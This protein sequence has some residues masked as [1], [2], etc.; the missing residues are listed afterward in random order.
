MTPK[1]FALLNFTILPGLASA[2]ACNNNC[3]RQVIGTAIREPPSLASRSSLCADFMTTYVTLA[4]SSEPS[5]PLQPSAVIDG[6]NVH[7]PRQATPAPAVTGTK[8]SYASACTDAAAYWSACQCF[9]GIKPTTITLIAPTVIATPSTSVVPQPSCTKGVEFAHYVLEPTS[10]LCTDVLAYPDLPADEYNLKS[11]LQ[12]RV[13]SGVGITQNLYFQQDNGNRPIS[14]AGYR[15]PTGSTLRCNILMHRGYIKAEAAGLYE[16][17]FGPTRDVVMIWF[18][19]KAKSGGFRAG[20]FDF[21]GTESDIVRPN[22][23][24]LLEIEDAAEYVPFRVY[25]SNGVGNGA[26]SIQAFGA[27]FGEWPD[28]YPEP[29]EFYTSCSG[30]ESP[31]PSWLAWGSEDYSGGV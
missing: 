15:G 2:A 11:L 31:A 19:N 28:G 5:A 16:I 7:G 21:G 9:D 30:P 17:F 27:F 14:Y 26:F 3:G 24:Y 23:S 20:N 29:P 8:P 4:A 18:G 25:W 22:D 6:R 12:S 10:T 13:P 1:W